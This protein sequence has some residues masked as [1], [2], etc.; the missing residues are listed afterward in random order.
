[1]NDPADHDLE[2]LLA[3]NGRIHHFEKG[4][5]A[6]FEI[7]KGEG[8]D[9]RPHGLSYSFTLHAPN[10]KRLLG[11][12]NAHAP[13]K[14]GGFTKKSKTNDHWHRD[15][16]DRGRPYAYKDAATL[17]EDFQIEV[18]RTLA[19]LGVSS[20]VIEADDREE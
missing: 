5:W 4:Y 17:L 2:Y 9:L 1:M 10:G 3:F 7:T 19:D 12:D 15:Q 14:G 11:F 8:T 18:E 13:P 6:K 20:D 16:T